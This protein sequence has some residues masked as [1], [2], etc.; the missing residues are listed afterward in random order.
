M[1]VEIHM[2]QTYS[3]S[4]PNRDDLGA[5]KRALFGG[6]SRLRISSQCIKRSIRRSDLLKQALGEAHLG[7]RTVSFPTLVEAALKESGIPEGEHAAIV[8]ACQSIAKAEKKPLVEAAPEGAIDV[9]DEEEK[10]TAQLIFLGAA[11]VREFVRVLEELRVEMPEEYQA[12]LSPPAEAEEGEKKGKGKAKKAAKPRGRMKAFQER[13]RGAF[14]HDAVDIALFG[15]M[16]TSDYF[17]NVEA[18]M[19]V[20]HA[21]STD[22]VIPEVDYY[23]A[24]DDLQPKEKTGSAFLDEAQ[25]G[26]ATFYKYFS[27]NFDLLVSNLAGD[28]ALAK[29]AVLAFVDAAAKANPTGKRNSYANNNLPDAILVEIREQNIPTSYSNAFLEPA[30]RFTDTQESYGVMDDS[31]RKLC[32]YAAQIEQ[33]YELNTQ[34]ILFAPARSPERIAKYFDN[35]A[36][37]QVTNLSALKQGLESALQGAGEP[38]HA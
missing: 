6:F 32:T 31:I 17:D 19:Q 35:A 21:I 16:T 24:V 20:A 2:L 34:R 38:V 14:T 1:L 7:Q 9:A 18:A 37:Q 36:L 8:N 22:E 28:A 15:R 26:S 5:P 27:L 23:T 13:L 25:F 3:P 12:F 10:R 33:G 4:N 11:E 29:Q 30:A